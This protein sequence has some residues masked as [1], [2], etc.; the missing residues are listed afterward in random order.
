MDT[1]CILVQSQYATKEVGTECDTGKQ[2]SPAITQ[3]LLNHDLTRLNG[4]TTACLN[5]P[6]QKSAL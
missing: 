2:R 5:L 4:L 3:R 6:Q 1:I